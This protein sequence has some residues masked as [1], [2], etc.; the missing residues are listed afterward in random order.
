M[1]TGGTAVL[2]TDPPAATETGTQLRPGL[3]APPWPHV[4]PVSPV[5]HLPTLAAPR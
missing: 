2:T 5:P 4:T 3:P 1:G